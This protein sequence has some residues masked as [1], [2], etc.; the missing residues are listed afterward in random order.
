M[1]L[2]RMGESDTC[3]LHPLGMH[4]LARSPR[5][6]ILDRIAA[7]SLYDSSLHMLHTCCA[8]RFQLTIKRWTNSRHSRNDLLCNV[9]LL[10]A[11]MSKKTQIK[12]TVLRHLL[13]RTH[14]NNN[15]IIDKSLCQFIHFIYFCSVKTY[16]TS[17]W[18]PFLRHTPIW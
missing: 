14:K 8:R 11:K 5:Q 4:C 18:K 6:N 13:S 9:L 15:V 7:F 12:R 2:L 10:L 3:Y 1:A 16:K 17:E